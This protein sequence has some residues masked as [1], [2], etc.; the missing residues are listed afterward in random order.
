MVP[1]PAPSWQ[2]TQ[3]SAKLH[4]PC[5]SNATMNGNMEIKASRQLVSNPTDKRTRPKL[6]QCS[7]RMAHVDARCP[8]MVAG[9]TLM[10]GCWV[11]GETGGF[12]SGTHAVIGNDSG[13]L[14]FS[15]KDWFQTVLLLLS[16]HEI[17]WNYI[18]DFP[19]DIF[20]DTIHLRVCVCACA[21]WVLDINPRLET[22]LS[23]ES[24]PVPARWK[25]RN[26]IINW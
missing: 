22:I 17:C 15:L 12:F 19:S 23:S 14:S 20:L 5:M 11:G 26:F 18:P 25:T 4:K 7:C 10:C 3:T 2:E 8:S 24:R 6:F 1:S 21:M 13:A 9:G 16:S